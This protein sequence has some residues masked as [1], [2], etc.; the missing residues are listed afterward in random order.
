ML[1][2]CRKGGTEV[3]R[4]N[5]EFSRAVESQGDKGSVVF[6]CFSNL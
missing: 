2:E 4:M 6:E 1:D 3:E 5:R